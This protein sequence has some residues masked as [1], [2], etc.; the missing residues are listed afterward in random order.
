[1]QAQSRKIVNVPQTTAHAPAA[2]VAVRTSPGVQQASALSV[3][4]PTDAAELEAQSTAKNV[5]R[6]P[7]PRGVLAQASATRLQRSAALVPQTGVQRSASAPAPPPVS[8]ATAAEIGS[9]RSS[10]SPLPSDVRGF[11]EPRFG[12]DFSAVRIHTDDRAA[13]ISRQLNAQ[14]FTVGN[15]MFFGRDRFQPD[16]TDGKEL[17]AHELTHTIQQGAALQRSEDV[18]VTTRAPESV[19]RLGVSDALDYFADKANY[20]PGFRMLTV[21]LGV[22]PINMSRVDRSAANVLR[23]AVEIIPAGS[24][25]SQALD[26]LGIFERVG[27]WVDQQLRTLSMTGQMFRAAIDKFLDSLGW[28]DIFSLGSV[29]ERAKQ[30]FTEPI[31]RLIEFIKGLAL[32]ILKFIKDA[33]LVPLAK[34]A[35]GTPGYDLLKA[36]LGRDPI[37]GEAVPQ[38]AETLIG[39]FMRLIGQGEIWE[40]L[41]RSNAVARAYAWF[42]G[43]LAG[44]MAFVNQIPG[45]FLAALQSLE[46]MDVVPPPRAFLKI[47][48]VFAGLV[49]RF[50]SWAGEQV[51]SLLE[52]IFDVV[53]PAVMPYVRKAAGAFKTIINNPIGFIGNLVKAAKLGFENFGANFGEH[54][55]A[56]LINWLT[57]SLPGVYIPK[58]FELKE[59][60]R[61]VFSVLGL[62]WQNIRQKLVKVM[63]EPVVKALETGFDIVVTLVRD[64]PAAAWD[65][66][67]EHLTNLKE[68]VIGGITDF[69]IDMVV[70]KAI[71]KLIAMFIPGAGFISAILSI[72]DTIMV[73]VQKIKQ[74]IEVVTGFIDSIAAIA[75]G[76]VTAAAGKVERI[77]ANLLSLAI[78]FFA[79]FIGL[80]KV[81]DKIMGVIQKIRTVIDKAIDALINW[82]VTMAKKVAK[83]AVSKAKALFSWAFSKSTFQDDAG[84]THTVSA[85]DT[86]AMTVASTPQAAELFVAD[87]IAKNGDPQGLGPK[88]N[89]KIKKA[90]EVAAE[91]AKAAA[92]V[93][94]DAIPAPAKQ[95]VLLGLSLEIS[96][97]LSKLVGRDS[98][99]GEALEKYKLE[100]QVGTYATVPKAV[101]DQLTP[102]HQPQASVILGAAD[103]FAKKLKIK[104]GPL[105]QRAESRAAQGYA[106]N[107]HFRR[108]VAGA[109]YGSKGDK[110]KDFYNDLVSNVSTADEEAAKRATSQRLRKLLERDVAAMKDVVKKGI[111]DDAWSDLKKE[112][113]IKTK[114]AKEKLR[115]EIVNQVVSGENQI[116]K[117]PFDF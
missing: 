27:N 81:S 73:F 14:A 15:Q 88:L 2:S 101:G 66:I 87:F 105:S 113:R 70:K 94:D 41:K 54:L 86:A 20:L 45:L 51:M 6:M 53:A 1:M 115:E 28:R 90:N 49:T 75:S 110:R 37:T 38:N 44:L 63:G 5:V 83:F 109:T 52:I 100:G 21:I 58:A 68:M 107:L 92:N 96:E 36:V 76:A 34:L 40:N 72:Y 69:V 106:I 74:I 55:K 116:A 50:L 8:S 57:G 12:A 104:G 77:L 114:S 108:H 80:G 17:I 65:K 102:D 35:E 19:Q 39:G 79:G 59:I 32:G 85:N 7:A 46:I 26:N 25:I 11:M 82:I 99:V 71:P 48:R 89:E 56:G 78:S 62:T 95:K 98:N 22:N 13:R 43:A 4:S 84:V 33:I 91:I 97:L 64:G 42:K 9:S 103:F 16:S 67:K 60:V 10:G 47:A 24:L 117:Q 23:A 31:G 61:F 112:N 29:W 111:D 3:S 18:S 30:I 93:A